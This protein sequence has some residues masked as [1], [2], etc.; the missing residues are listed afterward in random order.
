[1]K[2]VNPY[3]SKNNDQEY[4]RMFVDTPVFFADNKKV[5]CQRVPWVEWSV[6][7]IKR[8][9]GSFKL[10]TDTI[11]RDEEKIYFKE[12][13][14]IVNNIDKITLLW[15]YFYADQKNIYFWT[16]KLN[17]LDKDTFEIIAYPN[18][19][20]DKNGIYFYDEWICTKLPCD[21]DSRKWLGG[22]YSKDSKNVFFKSTTM[23]NIDIET[24]DFLGITVSAE[25]FA[26]DKNSYY[27]SY[28]NIVDLESV[29]RT[30]LEKEIID[31]PF[32]KRDRLRINW[33]SIY[34]NWEDI[35]GSIDIDF[36]MILSNYYIKDNHWV[37]W[38]TSQYDEISHGYK[39]TLILL[40]R[41]IDWYRI[42]WQNWEFLVTPDWIRRFSQKLSV[43]IQSFCYIGGTF[44]K[45]KNTV[46]NGETMIDLDPTS[47]KVLVV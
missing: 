16:K 11:G 3:L 38:I 14:V 41:S 8:H 26:M 13:P 43:D 35:T 46:F 39:N 44:Y 17:L 5:Y 21:N 20:K 22:Y 7:E 4:R 25:F 12:F 40:T 9:K 45:D 47:V 18:F 28:G 33:N 31:M 2:Y 24:F 30:L 29:D 27:D 36:C 23:Q 10:L 6:Y 37:Y 19:L 32:K 1:M 15:E 42:D 34:L